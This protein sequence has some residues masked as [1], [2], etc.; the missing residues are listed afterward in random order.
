MQTDIWLTGEVARFKTC[1]LCSQP[2]KQGSTTCFSCGFST[3]SPTSTSVW[4]DPAVYRLSSAHSQHHQI[5]QGKK[6]KPSRYKPQAHYHPNPITPIPPRASAQ[7]SNAANGSNV[8]SQKKPNNTT[9]NLNK[10]RGVVYKEPPVRITKT[11]A[12]SAAPM[13]PTVWE[14]VLST[15]ESSASASA[16][17][18]CITEEPTQPEIKVQ[19]KETRHLT[20]I[21]EITTIPPSTKYHSEESSR[22]L[23]PLS[24]QFDV[25]TSHRSD[26]I[27]MQHVPPSEVDAV[28]WT[29]GDAA[30]S[31]HARLISSRGKRKSHHMVVSLNPF[32]RLRWWLLRPGHIEFILWLGG[33]VLLVAV[34]CILLFVTAFSFEWITPGFNNQVSS[35][36]SGSTLGQGSKS[37]GSAESG[38]VLIRLDKGLILPGQTIELRGEGFSHGA[39]IRFLFDHTQQLFDQNGQSNSTQANAQGVFTASVVLGSNLPWHPGPHIINAQDLITM[40]MATLHIVLS[41]SPIGKGVSSTPMPSY[42]PNTTPTA[43]TPI[44][45]V[46]GSQPTAVGQTPVP[47]TPT[48][49]PVTP[50]PGTTPVITPTPATS[51]TVVPSVGTTP[52]VT[53]TTGTTG[54]SGL[55]NALDNAGGNMYFSKQLTHINPWVWLMIACYGLSMILLGLAGVLHKRHQ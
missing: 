2:F 4:I 45:T 41:P 51:P 20:Y 15:L 55:W 13:N 34:T 14:Y 11:P 33:T 30:Q 22:S 39:H 1:P 25:T 6:G 52:G 40:T 35:N 42:P 7:S 53:T 37:T 18:I 29:A 19:S 32:D 23:V 26:P 50:T 3:S 9:S 24:S 31:T 36:Q 12:H 10:P 47:V 54:G 43:L 8:D 27:G 17:Q 28:S 49:K 5:F 46:V 48:P 16:T 21:D 38:I 44:P